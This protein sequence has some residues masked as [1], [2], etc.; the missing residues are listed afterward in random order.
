MGDVVWLADRNA[1]KSQYKLA[2]V[3]KVNSDHKGV[4]RD[5]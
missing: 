3:V 1:L 5:V 4:V 2:R